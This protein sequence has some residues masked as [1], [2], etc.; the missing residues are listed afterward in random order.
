MISIQHVITLY[1]YCYGK[2]II[3]LNACVENKD[4]PRL[5]GGVCISVKYNAGNASAK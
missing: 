1:Q 4:Q 3:I 5:G 2:C